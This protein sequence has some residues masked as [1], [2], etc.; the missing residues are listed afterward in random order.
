MKELKNNSIAL[1]I[2]TMV[3]LFVLWNFVSKGKAMHG[4][5]YFLFFYVSIIVIHFFT[6][7]FPPKKDI[8]V[9]EPKKEFVMV[10]VFTL[11]GAIFISLSYYVK[12]LIPQIAV[13][14]KVLVFSG[15][16]L[17]TFPLGILIYMLLKR[18]KLLQLGL[19]TQP[20][21]YI[22]L[23]AI[24]WGMTGLFAYYF[25]ESGIIWKEGLKELGGFRGL[26]VQS[27]FSAALVEEFS[28]F[29]IQTRFERVY[30]IAG[31]NIL[32][33]TSI[34]AFFH[35]P[36]A[37]SKMHNLL[38]S[39]NYCLQIIPLGF[40]WGCMIQRTKSIIPSVLAHGFNLWGL[41]NG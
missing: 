3:N 18:Y 11:L 14:I 27:L 19:Y 13:P 7:K 24:I 22:V 2:M 41:Q 6:N 34:W 25:N 10:L 31:I 38:G 8:E 15:V 33:A 39:F 5:G 36:M 29:I 16:F 9:K 17:F 32:I 21:V 30:K 37:Y 20:L 1:V 35:F 28:R 4:I 40:V 12:G 23:G 26:I